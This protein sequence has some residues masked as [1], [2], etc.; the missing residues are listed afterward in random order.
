MR[1]AHTS[2]TPTTCQA[3]SGEPQGFQRLK[4][5]QL[6]AEVPR[7]PPFH[8]L[9]SRGSEGFLHMPKATQP[10]RG[11]MGL[12]P[13]LPEQTW[14]CELR[15]PASEAR[16]SAKQRPLGGRAATECPRGHRA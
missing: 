13:G 12:E 2:R 4:E 1:S 11:S 15:E 6:F 9:A 10:V 7:G 3:L 14:S 16:S 5:L 8:R